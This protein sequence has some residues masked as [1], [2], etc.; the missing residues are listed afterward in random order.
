MFL[1]KEW[2]GIFKNQSCALNSSE[3]KKR[4]PIKNFLNKF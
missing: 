4:K 2:T 3:K 1:G